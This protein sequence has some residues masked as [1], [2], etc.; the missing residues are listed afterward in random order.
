[1]LLMKDNEPV[2][3]APDASNLTLVPSGLSMPLQHELEPTRG[4][5]PD[6]GDQGNLK[7]QDRQANTLFQRQDTLQCRDQVTCLTWAV[8]LHFELLPLD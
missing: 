1:M 8:G 3:D 7:G 5:E 4:I 6:Q 2:Y